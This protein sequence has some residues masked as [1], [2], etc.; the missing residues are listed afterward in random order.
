MIAEL[1]CPLIKAEKFNLSKLVANFGVIVVLL[2]DENSIMLGGLEDRVTL[3]VVAG[4]VLTI[5]VLILSA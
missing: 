2:A 1:F 4:V 3:L 5:C